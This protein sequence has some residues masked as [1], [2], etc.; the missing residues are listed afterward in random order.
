M[1]EHQQLQLN[2]WEVRN[3]H[4]KVKGKIFNDIT[5]GRHKAQGT[6]RLWWSQKQDVAGTMEWVVLPVKWAWLMYKVCHNHALKK[7][8]Q[9]Q[10]Q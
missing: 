7:T 1:R 9:K 4:C 3:F 8:K 6:Y 5:L 10:I 2:I